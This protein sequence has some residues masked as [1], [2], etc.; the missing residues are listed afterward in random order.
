[1]KKYLVK[2]KRPGFLFF[3]RIRNVVEDGV[4]GSPSDT[5]VVRVFIT[6]KGR[7]VE[8]PIAST[9]FVFGPERQEIIAQNQ[10]A[11]PAPQ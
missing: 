4:V 3:R 11:K 2:Y 5:N 6:E 1:M 10:Q 8:V 9:V 7:R